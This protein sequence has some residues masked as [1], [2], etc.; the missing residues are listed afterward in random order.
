MSEE[1]VRQ[2]QNLT[3]PVEIRHARRLMSTE[4]DK[5]PPPDMA[6]LMSTRNPVLVL[7]P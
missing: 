2:P 4:S 1:K 3:E 6:P 7:R 5:K